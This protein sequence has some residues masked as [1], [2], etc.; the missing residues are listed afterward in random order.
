MRLFK[1]FFLILLPFCQLMAEDPLDSKELLNQID[2]P[3]DQP[4]VPT[5]QPPFPFEIEKPAVGPSED[6]FYYNL[7]QMLTSLGLLIAL[8]LFVSY[9][10]KKMLNTRVQQMNEHSVIKILE[11]RALSPKTTIYLLDIQDKGIIIAESLN[12]VTLLSHSIEADE[13][14]QLVGAPLE[15]K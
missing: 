13:T 12:G 2:N 9:F 7:M 3:V 15:I 5:D 1:Y 8:V 4:S 14:D 6:H 11:R 10:L